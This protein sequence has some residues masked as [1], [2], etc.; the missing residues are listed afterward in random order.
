MEQKKKSRYTEA[1]KKSIYKYRESKAITQLT[2]TP[3]QKELFKAAA[4][5]EN[6]S[7]NQFILDCII[8]H[9]NNNN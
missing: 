8:N 4:A 2:S 3:E 7:I 5:K 9:I 1:Q 6:K